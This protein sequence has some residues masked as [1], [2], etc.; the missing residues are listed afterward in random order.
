MKIWPSG[1][2]AAALPANFSRQGPLCCHGTWRNHWDVVH[3]FLSCLGRDASGTKHRHMQEMSKMS[4]RCFIVSSRLPAL[5]PYF[6]TDVWQCYQPNA[7][8]RVFG[9]VPSWFVQMHRHTL[10][11]R[12]TA[13]LPPVIQR[14]EL[15]FFS[16][17]L[18]NSNM[19]RPVWMIWGRLR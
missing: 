10:R 18:L 19:W 2:D 15:F 16:P 8:V 13:N 1:K 9:V 14:N 4:L 12:T 7:I 6:H 5:T 3:P 17:L 11:L